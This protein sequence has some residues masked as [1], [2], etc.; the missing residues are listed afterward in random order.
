[1]FRYAT[2]RSPV[3]ADLLPEGGF[4]KGHLA[5]ALA[6]LLALVLFAVFAGAV[7]VPEWTIAAGT[8]LAA[9]AI[10]LIDRTGR[11]S[12]ARLVSAL[13]FTLLITALAAFTGGIA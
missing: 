5:A 1:M 13:S 3:P 11:R 12:L 2:T 10:A 4:A 7:R 6:T 8:I 9:T